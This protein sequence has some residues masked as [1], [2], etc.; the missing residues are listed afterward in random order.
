VKFQA[1]STLGPI[2]GG[3]FPQLQFSQNDEFYRN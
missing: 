2:P 3:F 1:P